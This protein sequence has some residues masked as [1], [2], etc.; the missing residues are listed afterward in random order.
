MWDSLA[1]LRKVS[2]EDLQM[3]RKKK[4]KRNSKLYAWLPFVGGFVQEINKQIKLK[5]TADS[6]A[7][8]STRRSSQIKSILFDM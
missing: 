8:I 2:P 1:S 5:G 3:V 6:R 4:R 7:T